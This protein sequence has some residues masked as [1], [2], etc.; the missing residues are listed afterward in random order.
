[1]KFFNEKE[2]DG[3]IECLSSTRILI[4]CS[5]EETANNIM[6]TINFCST[7]ENW[8]SNENPAFWAENQPE[9]KKNLILSGNI[10][11]GCEELMS[12]GLISK[13]FSEEF[14][15][16]YEKINKKAEEVLQEIKNVLGNNKENR[17]VIAFLV[18]KLD[19]IPL[20]KENKE[21]L[22]SLT[23]PKK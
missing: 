23:V 19:S 2:L 1:M 15:S 9:N 18:E 12:I 11:E 3:K 4:K 14:L 5:S 6:A 21:T 8:D 17:H 22:L 10:K 20:Q 16:Y 7:S 13:S